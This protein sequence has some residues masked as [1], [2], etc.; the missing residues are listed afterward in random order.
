MLAVSFRLIQFPMLAV[1]FGLIQFPMLAVSFGLLQFPM[2]AVCFGLMQFLDVG[3]WSKIG[4]PAHC[5]NGLKQVSMLNACRIYYS[6]LQNMRLCIV[7]VNQTCV[8][9][10]KYFSPPLNKHSACCLGNM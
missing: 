9:D 8:C 7:T 1:S 4:H 2:L 3:P 10:L 5:H 6:K